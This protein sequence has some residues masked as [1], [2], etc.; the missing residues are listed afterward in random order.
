MTEELNN[1]QGGP[2]DLST[3]MSEALAMYQALLKS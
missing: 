3:L 1:Y 2:T